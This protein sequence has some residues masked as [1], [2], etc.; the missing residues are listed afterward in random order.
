M[1]E[2][3]ASL[4]LGVIAAEPGLSVPQISQ[5]T[6]VASRT[7]RYYMHHLKAA[8]RVND[9]RLMPDTRRVGYFGTVAQ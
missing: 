5:R 2:E 6:G 1:K 8:G 7:V 9:R 4:F 3:K